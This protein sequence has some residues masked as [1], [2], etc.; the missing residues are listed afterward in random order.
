M[1]VREIWLSSEDTG[2]YGLDIGTDVAQLLDSLVAVLPTDGAVMLRLGMTNPPFIL[3]HLQ[4][5]AKVRQCA[6]VLCMAGTSQNLS[7][8][9]GE[10][11]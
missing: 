9:S 2:A 7:S 3:R 1:Q 11:V 5:V 6:R 8:K 10:T 4:A